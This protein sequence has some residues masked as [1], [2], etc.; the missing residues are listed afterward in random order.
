MLYPYCAF[1]F[2]YGMHSTVLIDLLWQN[3]GTACPSYINYSLKRRCQLCS[4]RYTAVQ[5][6][7]CFKNNF[8]NQSSSITNGSHHVPTTKLTLL[9]WAKMN[10]TQRRALV[11]PW[12]MHYKYSGMA[13]GTSQAEV[14]SKSEK[15]EPVTLAIVKL[16]GS[17]GIRQLVS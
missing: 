5:I 11:S 14:M 12:R 4:T 1:P 2:W 13:K 7:N 10:G 6:N 8:C 16:C 9:Q 17:E 15:I 3:N